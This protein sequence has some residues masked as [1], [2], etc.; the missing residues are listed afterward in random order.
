M[1]YL[2]DHTIWLPYTQM[3]TATP[4]IKIVG[5]EKEYLI[6]DNGIKLVDAIGSWW[7][8]CHGYN[9]PHIVQA[10]QNQAQTLPHVMMGGI[11]HAP[12]ERL[13]HRLKQLLPG[14]LDHTFLANTGSEAME[15]AMKMAIQSSINQNQRKTKFLHF[16]HSYHGDTLYAMSICDPEEGMHHIFGQT[17]NQQFMQTIPNSEPEFLAFEQYL[18]QH[19]SELAGV[20]IE[21]LVQ[22]AG[23]M[24]MHNSKQLKKI[25]NLC[26]QYKI[27]FIVDEIFT[28]FGR[29][30]SLFA[31]EQAG[32][33]PDIICLSKALTGG[34]LPL[35]AVVTRTPLYQTFLSDNP[36]K[37]LMHGPTFMGNALACAAANASLDLFEQNLWQ[38]QVGQI[39]SQLLDGLEDLHNLPQVKEVRVKGAIGA[40]ELCCPLSS[41]DFKWFQKKFLADG[42]WCR[43]F[44]NIVYATPAFNIEERNLQKIITSISNHIKTWSPN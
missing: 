24:K 14:D 34:T 38:K 11:I 25:A 39:Q 2:M 42:V 21:P 16:Q 19:Q 20:I 1:L 18:I 12:A 8:A 43:P 9:H 7:T 31:I 28:G 33:V 6:T 30:G 5:T 32:I 44:G 15:I 35:A 29:T 41:E 26:H 23:G 4:P 37:A 27:C 13:C 3:H 22:G 36:D 40:V 17:L 10:I